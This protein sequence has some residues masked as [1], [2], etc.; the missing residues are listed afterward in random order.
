[1]LAVI[2]TSKNF[3]LEE[4]NATNWQCTSCVCQLRS[5]FFVTE[6]LEVELSSSNVISILT[7]E[8]ATLKSS[9][10]KLKIFTGKSLRNALGIK[11]NAFATDSSIC[12]S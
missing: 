1:M 2:C 6:N 4:N 3:S 11:W 12:Q 9:E 5:T 10:T 8:H 7:D